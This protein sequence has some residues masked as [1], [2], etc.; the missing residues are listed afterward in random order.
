VLGVIARSDLLFTNSMSTQSEV[1]GTLMSVTGRVGIDGF[2]IASDGTPVKNYQAYMTDDEKLLE[3]AYDQTGYRTK[4][5][6]K[7]SLRRI[8]G[9]VSNNRIVETYIQPRSDGTSYVDSGFKR[10]SMKFDINLIF[11]PPPNF[12]EVPRP[13]LTYYAPIFFVRNNG[14]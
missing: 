4:T 13:V 1:N 5:F 3:N 10:G 8:G 11:N 6:V 12:V 7:D 14:E 9:I 2:A